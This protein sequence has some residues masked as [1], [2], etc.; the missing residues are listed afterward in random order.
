MEK[1][2]LFPVVD[3]SPTVDAGSCVC[4]L[5]TT[6]PLH[7]GHPASAASVPILAARMVQKIQ[8]PWF[9]GGTGVRLGWGQS[10]WS[11]CRPTESFSLST[12]LYSH[13]HILRIFPLWCES[14]MNRM[15]AF[16]QLFLK[17]E[18]LASCALLMEVKTLA[19]FCDNTEKISNPL[20]RG[21][22]AKQSD[23]CFF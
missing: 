7:T 19:I 4:V 15:D 10:V 2:S 14:L 21:F 16:H 23:L 22:L 6:S 13:V 12:C 18:A 20:L 9:V 17:A 1:C 3:Q 11:S 8:P 5:Q